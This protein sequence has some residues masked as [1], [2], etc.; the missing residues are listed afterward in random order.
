MDKTKDFSIVLWDNDRDTYYI[1]EESTG[2]YI[3]S[4]NSVKKAR[5]I[6][7]LLRDWKKINISQ[8]NTNHGR[9]ITNKKFN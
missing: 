2:E 1:Y 9:I 7:K 6:V 3:C 5:N 4:T 8:F